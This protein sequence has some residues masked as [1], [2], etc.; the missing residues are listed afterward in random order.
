[1]STTEDKLRQ[2]LKRVTLDLGQARQRLRE[3][4][5]RHREPIAI[6]AMACRYPGG[7]TSPEGLWDVVASGADA[8]GPFP[9]NRGWD[10][11]HLFHPDP[12][13]PGTSY[14]QE[15]GF[16]HDADEFDASFFNISPREALAMD[17]Q[18]RL[19]LEVAWELLERARI[20][21]TT[22]KGTPTGVYAG[23][24]SQDYLSRI[25]RI[26]EGFE[27]YTATG[28]L[29]SVVSGRVA[30]ALGLEGPAVTLDT[31]CSS[32]L[33]AT[34]LAVR[35]LRQGECTL[36]LAGGVTVFTAATAF[37]EFSKQRG[38]APDARCKAFAAAADGTGFSEGAGLVLLE[39]L[40][41]ARRNG[42][43][44]LA[45]IRGSAVNQDGASN[46]LA[47][48][49]DAAQERVIRQALADARLPADQ[50]DAVEA[51]G[52]G[53]TL[54]DPIEAEALL[55]TYGQ[56][57]PED[58]PLWLGSI[59][60][61][62]GHTQAAAG[63]AGVI[64]MVMALRHG[65]LP[66][67]LHV[68]EPTSH[69]DWSSGAV[70]LLT[71]PV[72]W[73]TA[74]RP[75]GA[76][77]SAFGISGTNAHVIL[78]EAPE[79]P[80]PD[81]DEPGVL[82]GVAP[83]VLSARTHEALAEQARRLTRTI[84]DNPGVSPTEVAWSLATTRATFDRR[85]VV[86]G[87]DP[88]ELLAALDALA[89]GGEHPHLTRGTAL[90][91][92][93]GPVFVFPGQ[94]SQ[95]AGMAVGL[96]DSS[97]AFASRIAACEQALAPYVDWSLTAVLRGTDTTTDPQRVDVIQ[98]TLWAMMVSLAGMWQDFGVTPAAVIGHSQGEI[99]AACVAGAL[100]LEDAAKV[101][102]LR[103]QALRALAGH[104]AM[105]SLTLTADDTAR[106]LADLG[107]TAEGVAIAAHNG[108]RSTVISGPPDQI[109]TVLTAA[110][111]QGARTRTIDVDYASHSPHVD[112]IRDTILDQLA[113]LTPTTPTIPFYSTVTTER[114]TTTPLDADY[115]FTNLRQPVRFTNTLTTL[116]D[117]GH[118]HFIEAG[119]HPVLTPGIQ[120]TIDDA[121]IPAT[122]IPT[123]R[124]DHGTPHDLADALA[125]AHTTGLTVNWR[126]WYPAT[127][128][129]TTDLP[130]YPFQRERFWLPDELT[131]APPPEADE[132]EVRFWGAVDGLDLPALSETLGLG[133]EDGRRSSLG[134]VLPTLS[135]WHRERH[136]RTTV[137]SWRYR[138]GW[139]PLPGPG[140]AAVAGSWLLVVGPEGAGAWADAC[141]Q[142][143]TAGGGEV[144]R[145]VADGRADPAELAASLRAVCAAGPSLAGV[146]S[147]LPLDERPH[148]TYPAVIGGVTGTLVLLRALLEAELDAPLWCATRGAVAVADDER[149]QAPAQAQVWG[150]GRVAALE[151]PTAWGG[152]VDLPASVE[153]LVPGLLCATLAGRDGE[154]QVALR[155]AGAFARRLLPAPLDA[156]AATR[157][158][159]PR[160]GVLV[161]GG[162]AGAAAHVARW[163]AT[164]GTKR[165][166][167]LA[168][169]G[170]AAPGGAELVAE[171]AELGAEATVVDGVPS[172]PSGRHELADRLAASGLR[173]RTIIHTGAPGDRT[174]LAELTPDRL[175]ESLSA[176][177]GGAD[178]LPEL[179][180]LEPDDPV[181]VFS[182]VVAVWGAGEHGARAAADAYLDAVARR[183][184]AA[185]GPVVRVAWG[186]WDDMAE[187]AAVERS[188]R[189]GL[190]ALD[191]ALALTALRRT[192]DQA[193]HDEAHA[194][195]ADVDWERF[196][197]LF[198][199]G[200]ASRLF[201][202][203]PA[204]RRAGRAAPGSP[205]SDDS[206]SLTAL[207]DRLAAQKPEARTGTLLALVRAHAASALRYS[208]A[209]LV[210]PDQPF[211]ELGFDSLTAVEFR[212]RLRDATGL[213]LSPTLVFD[214]PTPT[215]L[216][217]HLVSRVL[218]AEPAEV[219]A[220]EHLDGIEAALAALD[221]D[222]PRRS[223]LTHRL[224]VLLWR[225]TDGESASEPGEETG[226]DDLETASA[227]EVF[228]LIDRE[229][230]ES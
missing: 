126:P 83:W 79:A 167:L 14:V 149:P 176:A 201:D 35:A 2:Y 207:R 110:E 193:G 171:L 116:L 19:L 141:E 157:E 144:R 42:H 222:D 115:W 127:K 162:V 217:G 186:V 61:N 94:G 65:T 73:P 143:L 129:T 209:E 103:S 187:R 165:I 67:T 71:V 20:D 163:L 218:P 43:H 206:G 203:I 118:R 96:L 161:T 52:T 185:G 10:L 25:P 70:R 47:A 21:P 13:H 175:A 153:D 37:V 204:A 190:P 225:Y 101:V 58:R 49:N 152:L 173:V 169:G 136:E 182:S 91:P 89:D 151:H 56:E 34:H 145:L 146:L 112:R 123:L 62:I 195:F 228:A 164:G 135:R 140:P 80:E 181:V 93:Q 114:L 74:E 196:A 180:G 138:I 202:E 147:L 113:D 4:E 227:D 68:D 226:G 134:A 16:L 191:P 188:G 87:T 48:P 39:R 223:G 50:V 44:V 3:V 106:I 22:L 12:D 23:V 99:A 178:R 199:L 105:A 18:Q 104:G 38:F 124:R 69:V 220:A 125:H 119:P 32:S 64:K 40:S 45:V 60:S 102:A 189:H 215:A 53:T 208:A 28:G 109:A 27:G 229:F 179:C 36:A 128:P 184:E 192:L 98:P 170:Q 122:T 11:D 57:R 51:H 221:A 117:R 159:T 90:D 8:L 17:P 154:D 166:V 85:A 15:G 108:P 174:P 156:E 107:E 230:G 142:A 1:M 132:E 139:R 198:T 197:P 158:W 194:V 72:D 9:A 6:I 212:N 172:E 59:K 210:E 66:A 100:T 148:E 30:Y 130:T 29:T 7:V 41:D 211:N 81:A 54:G 205:E 55:A 86:T 77:V 155:P 177:V 95:W 92:Q 214:Y 5:E 160:E 24:S 219:P 111:T 88:A 200:R 137:N 150:L 120:D 46:G 183:R 133:E 78:E 97:P 26:P 63:I 31:A 168:P 131:D 75:R 216:A 224:Q 84:T 82:G 213:T 121:D 33:V 76:G